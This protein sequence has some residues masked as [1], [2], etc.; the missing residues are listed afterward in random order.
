MLKKVPPRLSDKL[1]KLDRL[2]KLDHC[3]M[4]L[5]AGDRKGECGCD[6][7]SYDYLIVLNTTLNSTCTNKGWRSNTQLLF[8]CRINLVPRRRF[9]MHLPRKSNSTNPTKFHEILQQ[10]QK[11]ENVTAC[12]TEFSSEMRK[13]PVA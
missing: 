11:F 9:R 13:F 3:C 6:W 4:S 5:N 2:L 8:W 10:L 7:K 12:T 1:L